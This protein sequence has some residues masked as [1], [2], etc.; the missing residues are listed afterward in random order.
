MVMLTPALAAVHAW[1]SDLK[2]H[3]VSQPAFA[4]VLE[5]NPA[6]AS[7]VP[8]RTVLACAQ[9]L[10]RHKF[11][12]LFN[13]HGGPTSAVLAAGAKVPVRVC[14]HHCQFG[15]VYNVRVPG[16]S[17]FFGARAVHRCLGGV[18]VECLY[19]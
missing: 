9:E 1:R 18:L 15:F 3:V 8:F 2:L 4:A 6:I 11:P 13:Q 10:R 12:V 17:Q 19:A 16:T 7:V 5:G 14:W